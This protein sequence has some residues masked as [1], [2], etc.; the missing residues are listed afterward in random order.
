[1]ENSRELWKVSLVFPVGNFSGGNSRYIYEY[2]PGVTSPRLFT[3]SICAAILNFGE[4]GDR[5]EHVL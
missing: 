3:A 5:M 1:M 4:S 2:S